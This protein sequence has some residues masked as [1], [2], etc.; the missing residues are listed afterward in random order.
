MGS[1]EDLNEKPAGG[2]GDDAAAAGP[3]SEAEVQLSVDAIISSGVLGKG[4]R[5]AA[6]LRYL[7]DTEL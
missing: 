4:D 1:P 7:V 6:L 2:Q 5:R 3:P